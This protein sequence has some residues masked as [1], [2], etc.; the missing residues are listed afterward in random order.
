MNNLF[1][2][3][4]G[5][6]TLPFM[7]WCITMVNIICNYATFRLYPVIGMPAYLCF[8]LLGSAMSFIAKDTY[9]TSYQIRASTLV[10]IKETKAKAPND[11]RFKYR[12]NAC[13]PLGVHAYFF[14]VKQGTILTYFAQVI[15]KTIFLLLS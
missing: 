11:T 13:K 8:P 15:D 10:L 12:M 1:N 14:M 3:S 7:F 5:I 2:R 4:F 6:L 9:P